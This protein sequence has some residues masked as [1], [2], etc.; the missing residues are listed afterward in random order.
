MPA[1]T[2]LIADETR[3]F[4]SAAQTI[5]KAELC[6]VC[7]AHVGGF[8]AKRRKTLQDATRRQEFSRLD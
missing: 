3:G 8:R 2:A 7:V 6:R 5:D 1:I 4:L